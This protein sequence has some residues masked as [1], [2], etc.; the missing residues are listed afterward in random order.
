MGK[1][2]FHLSLQIA[3]DYPVNHKKKVHFI[4]KRWL[5][6]QLTFRRLRYALGGQ[7]KF[8]G[9]G[10]AKLDTGLE[11]FFWAAGLPL[12]QGYGLTETSPL[13]TLNR[14]PLSRMKIGT[15]GP[16]IPGVKVK[17][18]EEDEI[19]C[20]GPNVMKGYYKEEGLTKNVI[21]PEGWFHTGDLGNLTEEG[22]L[23]IK[24]RKKE[25]FKTSYGKYIVP[26]VIES[27]FRESELI[28][29]L[30]VLGEGEKFTAALII[31]DFEQLF[32]WV[33]S[34]LKMQLKDKNKVV[35]LPQVRNLF[36]REVNQVNQSLGMTERI[37]KFLILPENWSVQSGEFSPTLKL[38]RHFIKKKYNKQIKGIYQK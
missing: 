17:I 22:F 30:M 2:L 7:I 25:L 14:Q 36:Q 3:T 11:K 9:C 31:P 33:N 18:N 15:V 34:N 26:Q 21:D 29:Q 19:L 6:G 28:S 37:K 12:Y 23:V 24:G 27:R 5:I 1:K 32:R 13:I 35:Q 16:V 38:K 20:K 8:I 10:G 4:L